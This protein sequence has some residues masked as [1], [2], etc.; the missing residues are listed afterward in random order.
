MELFG[1]EF[2]DEFPI[3]YLTGVAAKTNP[4]AS[5]DLYI[6]GLVRRPSEKS[7]MM[8]NFPKIYN[9][10]KKACAL[11]FNI[12]GIMYNVLVVLTNLVA[13]SLIPLLFYIAVIWSLLQIN[14]INSDVYA[15][16]FE[17][18]DIFNSSY[19]S[20][21]LSDMS[22]KGIFYT[23]GALCLLFVF[24]GLIELVCFFATIDRDTGK[25]A[26]SKTW[27]R[28]IISSFFWVM[29]LIFAGFYVAYI[30]VILL[31]CILGAVLNPEKFLPIATGAM[32][33][34]VFLGLMYSKLSYIDKTL[35]EVVSNVVNEQLQGTMIESIQKKANK[36]Q[37]ELVDKFET[38]PQLVFNKAINTFMRMNNHPA[39]DKETTNEIL[40]GNAGAIAK[41]LHQNCG[42]DYAIGLGLVGILKND[43]VVILD[44]IYKVSM[45]L[46]ID[47]IISVTIAE[48]VLDKYDS[49]KTLTQKVSA[50]II[51]SV[52]KLIRHLFPAFPSEML[53]I[54]LEIA[55]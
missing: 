13:V 26:V 50:S 52:K 23:L 29:V 53:D 15:P 46:D 21:W 11:L 22:A 20:F 32:V 5:R 48:L 33:I 9:V 14:V 35:K 27:P 47:P 7:F 31:W 3:P 8:R 25:Y 1:A 10:Y 43:P 45:E 4:T 55:L 37:D 2:K 51:L 39:V 30:S 24:F 17:L 44:S 18:S 19:Y 41:M 42:L 38:M 12:D 54:I 6:S 28:W 49:D 36:A 34:L 16:V 40:K